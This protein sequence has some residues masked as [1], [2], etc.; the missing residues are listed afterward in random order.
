MKEFTATTKSG[1]VLDVTGRTVKKVAT[2]K[3]ALWVISLN[4]AEAKRELGIAF[5]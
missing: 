3:E 4:A 2:K 5:A 1:I